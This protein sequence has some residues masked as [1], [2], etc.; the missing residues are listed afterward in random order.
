MSRVLSLDSPRAQVTQPQRIPF[1]T[2]QVFTLG[3]KLLMLV[4]HLKV[5]LGP[6]F[7]NTW[8]LEKNLSFYCYFEIQST[9]TQLVE[10]A[11]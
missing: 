7:A 8:F 4:S 6:R 9:E 1:E 2:R 3:Y 11:L 10:K 5:K